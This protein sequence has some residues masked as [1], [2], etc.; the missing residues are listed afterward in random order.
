MR[1]DPAFNIKFLE[2]IEKH[3]VLYD[4]TMDQYSNRHIQKQTWNEV[5]AELNESTTA[6]K[7]KWKNIRSAF[8]RY[9]RQKPK[10]SGLAAKLQRSYYLTDYL[11]FLLPY[12]KSRSSIP[13]Q[14]EKHDET[15]NS[16]DEID[17]TEGIDFENFQEETPSEDG[18]LSND[19]E[20]NI[21]ETCIKQTIKASKQTDPLEGE[22]AMEI[23]QSTNS[24]M[25]E[26]EDSD[27]QFV[28]KNSRMK[29]LED[30][31]LQF[32]K[33][34]LPDM[35]Q[36]NSRQKFQFKIG[37]MQLIGHI[38]YNTSAPKSH[39]HASTSVKTS[40]TPNPQTY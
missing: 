23:F 3:R 31:D 24:R 20:S 9:L 40:P 8:T 32:L 29:E 12:T 35:R 15:N 33:S 27:V 18:I 16:F 25:K 37:T 21:D 30:S 10:K 13:A 7:E 19:Q 22:C 2:V 11:Q 17:E 38:L 28:S 1:D 36:M 34:I 14:P 26:L 6:C 4:Y 39:M 5:A